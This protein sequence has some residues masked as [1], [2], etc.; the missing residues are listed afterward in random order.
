M[1]GKMAR[2]SKGRA[3]RR[4]ATGAELALRET[5]PSGR[6]KSWWEKISFGSGN[7]YWPKSSEAQ[8]PGFLLGFKYVDIAVYECLTFVA[9]KRKDFEVNATIQFLEEGLGHRGIKSGAIKRSL[10]R[11][12]AAG[13]L[14]KYQNFKKGNRY[15]VCP[16]FLELDT[17]RAMKNF[18]PAWSLYIEAR[19]A[20]RDAEFR[21]TAARKEATKKWLAAVQS[22]KKKGLPVP[23]IDQF[24]T[25]VQ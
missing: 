17:A 19:V 21:E 22:A 1:S 6:E 15:L 4:L 10:R 24:V 14:K 5:E 20:E 2:G 11:W 16:L 3:F 25:P 12:S 18:A 13:L 23:E 8:N 7:Q 9:W